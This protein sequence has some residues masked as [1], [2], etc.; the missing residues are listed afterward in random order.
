MHDARVTQELRH[1]AKGGQSYVLKRLN[2]EQPKNA[3]EFVQ[4]VIDIYTEAYILSL[5]N[6]PHILQ[7]QG[8]VVDTHPQSLILEKLVEM[9]DK[10]LKT[11]KRTKPAKIF[12][13]QGVKT[14]A[15]WEER[16]RVASHISSALAYL[17]EARIIFRDLKPGNVGKFV[18]TVSRLSLRCTYDL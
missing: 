12:D 8:I 18:A 3:Q 16:I 1:N 10:R 15:H 5:L 13:R 17:H 9:F 4:A 6:H 14:R 11:W 2:L 7:L